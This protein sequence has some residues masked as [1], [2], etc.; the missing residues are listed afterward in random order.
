MASK[1]FGVIPYGGDT[2]VGQL[3]KDV[4]HVSEGFMSQAMSSKAAED[5]REAKIADA[6]TDATLKSAVNLDSKY[7]LFKAAAQE[8]LD[9]YYELRDNPA[10]GKEKAKW[11][12]AQPGFLEQENWLTEAYRWSEANPNYTKYTGNIVPEEQYQKNITNFKNQVKGR[13]GNNHGDNMSNLFVGQADAPQQTDTPSIEDTTMQTGDTAIQAGA[14]DQTKAVGMVPPME[15]KTVS[16]QKDKIWSIA[17]AAADVGILGDDLVKTG[18]L[19]PAELAVWNQTTG[20][21]DFRLEALKLV[22]DGNKDLFM[23]ILN[24]DPK[25][26][27]LASGKISALTNMVYNQIYVPIIK[28]QGEN[29]Q[30]Y[31]PVTIGN[32]TY[33][34]TTVKDDIIGLTPDTNEVIYGLSG[35]ESETF[36]VYR[37][38][39]FLKARHENGKTIV[40]G[41]KDFKKTTGFFNLPEGVN[42]FLQ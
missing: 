12:Y 39:V 28:Q 26:I 38:G 6:V 16:Q 13:F 33:T 21:T 34:P 4:G 3:V 1:L 37:K 10:I 27:E 29:A 32:K 22:K 23:G 7:P 11:M 42:P 15:G 31:T 30:G 14:T 41:D 25:A 24:Q 17:L 9:K 20:V 35:D 36:Y 8:K 18:L 5:T 2:M 19:N 40:E